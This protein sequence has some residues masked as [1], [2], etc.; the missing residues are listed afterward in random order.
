MENIPKNLQLISDIDVQAASQDGKKLPRFSMLAYTGGKMDLVG[1]EDP[2]V[3]DLAGIGI[4]KQRIPIR[5]DHSAGKG[6][7]HTERI[8]VENNTLTAEGIVSRDTSWARDVAKSGVNGFPGQASIGAS[9]EETEFVAQGSAVTVNGSTFAG[10]VFVVRESILKEISFVDLGADSNTEAKIAAKAKALEQEKMA[11]NDKTKNEVVSDEGRAEEIKASEST[12]TKQTEQAPAEKI[13]ASG[14][15]H[16]SSLRAKAADEVRRIEAVRSLCGDSHGDI[17]AKAIEEGWDAT[18]TELEVLR[19][20]RPA[21]PAFGGQHRATGPKVFEAAAVMAGGISGESLEASYDSPTLEAADKM[22][23]MGIQEFC[24]CASGRS[25]PR[26]RSNPSDWLQ[27]AFSTM[28]LPYILSNVANK[29]LLDGYNYAEDTWRR[30]CKISSVNDFKQ[31]TRHR[32]TGDFKFQE[33]GADGE[34]K[35]G[36][37]SEQQFTQQADTHGIMF[38]LTRQAIINDDLSAFAAI[39]REIG[40]GAGEAIADA[41]WT[42]ILSNPSSFF[43]SGNG[44]YATGSTTA[45]DVDAL[46]AAELLFLDQTKPNGRPLGIS[47]SILL[48]PSALKVTAEQLMNSLQLNETTTANAGKPVNNPHAGKFDIA[49]SSY[50]GNSSFTGYSAL[51]WYLFADPNRLAAFEV[52]FLN[53]VDRP[54]VESTDADFNTLG[55]QF[56]GYIDFGVKEQDYRGAVKMKGEA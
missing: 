14:D 16:L 22:R 44:N 29:M 42:L 2:V 11:E 7:G 15:D 30:I 36:T 45:L 38:S 31:H 21:A 40:M 23:G 26:F 34:L 32:M 12:E 52:A 18:K 41:V 28:S 53:G 20:S 17:A 50:L 27:A 4:E 13:E 33:V 54:T 43:A 39:P 5:L 1:F 51:A 25:L 19:A 48:V 37:V 47:P 55:V 24:E 35:H 3:V 6:V 8:A 56:R 9:I 49:S 46:T 10:P